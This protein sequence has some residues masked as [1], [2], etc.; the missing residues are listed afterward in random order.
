MTRPHLKILLC[1]DDFEVADSLA[2]ILRM[3]GQIVT[4][5]HDGETAVQCAAKESFDIAFLD[6]LLPGMNGVDCFVALKKLNSVKAIHLMTG[7]AGSDLIK[8]A[9]R[10]GIKAIM[11]K[12]VRP[13]D[14]L[15]CLTA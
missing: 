13:E 8:Q 4:I 15:A 11:R 5:T 2:Y 7:Y 14:V 9:E 10:E 6:I 12:P 1:E 3:H